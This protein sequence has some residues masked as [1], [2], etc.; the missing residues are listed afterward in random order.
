MSASWKLAPSMSTPVSTACFSEAPARS[1]WNTSAPVKSAPSSIV[2]IIRDR[3]SRAPAST[4]S[5]KSVA[6]MVPSLLCAPARLAPR[7]TA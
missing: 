6:T 1:V 3:V 7:M 5:V 4:A 2:R